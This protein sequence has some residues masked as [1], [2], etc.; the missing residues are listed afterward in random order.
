MST[1]SQRTVAAS[2]V[3]KSGPDISVCVG[4]LF[5]VAIGGTFLIPTGAHFPGDWEILSAFW[6]VAISL[7]LAVWRDGWNDKHKFNCE[8]CIYPKCEW[9]DKRESVYFCNSWEATPI[10]F[11]IVVGIP[12]ALVFTLI[13]LYTGIDWIRVLAWVLASIGWGLILLWA[14]VIVLR[15]IKIPLTPVVIVSPPPHEKDCGC[16]GT[17]FCYHCNGTGGA[18]EKELCLYCLGTRLC[19]GRKP[20]EKDELVNL[21]KQLIEPQI[22]KSTADSEVNDQS[23]D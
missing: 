19:P 15:H 7:A 14:V 18:S 13:A 2:K 20:F 9:K 5:F 8:V 23:G 4:V 6:I 1:Y 11:G 22:S 3:M 16:E 10:Y 21:W 12:F 17:G